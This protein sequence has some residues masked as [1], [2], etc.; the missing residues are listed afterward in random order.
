MEP[1]NKT[2][3]PP[4]IKLM[5]SGVMWGYFT[6][7]AYPDMADYQYYFFWWNWLPKGLRYVGPQHMYYDGWHWSFGFW[8]INWSWSTKWAYRFMVP[9]D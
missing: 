7:P 2:I 5:W 9:K 8:F 1:R 3:K 4:R 6:P